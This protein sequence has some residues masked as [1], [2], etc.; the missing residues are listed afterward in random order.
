MQAGTRGLEY[1]YKKGLAAVVMEPVRGGRLAKP[2]EK[3][4]KNMG[5]CARTKNTRWMGAALG[6]EPSGSVGNA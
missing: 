2:P 6:L 5:K 3:V 1:A 4:A